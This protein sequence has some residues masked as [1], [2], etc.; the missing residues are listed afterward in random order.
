MHHMRSG[1]VFTFT[2][3]HVSQHACTHTRMR[4]HTHT[5][6]RTPVCIHVSILHRGV[7][8]SC[9]QAKVCYDCTFSAFAP[10]DGS[11]PGYHTPSFTS[12]K[13]HAFL[14]TF[15]THSVG[16][17]RLLCLQIP[18]ASSSAQVE[19]LA[20]LYRVLK[21]VY[22]RNTSTPALRLLD[23]VLCILGDD[24]GVEI[25]ASR[26]AAVSVEGSLHK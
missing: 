21:L 22:Q 3:M 10:I 25:Y 17:H 23:D 9:V 4:A 11:L 6:A 18:G 7:C 16:S 12:K 1:H 2:G 8:C 20:E 19:V 15:L 24:L 5:H 26:W 14:T 13:A